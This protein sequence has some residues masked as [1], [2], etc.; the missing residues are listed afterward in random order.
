MGEVAVNSERAEQI[1]RFRQLVAQGRLEI[2]LSR[3]RVKEVLGEPEEVGCTS[4]RYPA[5]SCYRPWFS[6]TSGFAWGNCF[7]PRAECDGRTQ[8]GQPEWAGRLIGC[9]GGI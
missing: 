8:N 2:G 6:R 4:R 5:P 9:G 3:E 7:L 1:E